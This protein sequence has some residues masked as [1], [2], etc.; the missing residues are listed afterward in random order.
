MK[1]KSEILIEGSEILKPLIFKKKA[2]Y[3][4]KMSNEMIEKDK[5][6][7]GYSEAID[8]ILQDFWSD[9]K[10]HDLFA[11][12]YSFLTGGKATPGVYARER[13]RWVVQRLVETTSIF[14]D[15][16]LL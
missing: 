5:K 15:R 8:E 13:S 9:P 14:P 10:Q 12:V 11:K 6:F 7:L 3:I 4:L 1:S 2:D 16:P